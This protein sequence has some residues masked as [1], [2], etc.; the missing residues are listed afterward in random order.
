MD[1]GYG[2]FLEPQYFKSI[3]SEPRVLYVHNPEHPVFF[4]N[5]SASPDR[6]RGCIISHTT[7]YAAF[8]K[9]LEHINNTFIS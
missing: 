7:Y 3:F 6:E 8:C 2:Y 1:S 9:T 5:H 4:L